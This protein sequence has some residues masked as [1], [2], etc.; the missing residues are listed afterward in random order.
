MNIGEIIQSS[1]CMER[2]VPFLYL[3]GTVQSI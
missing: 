3:S 1:S 2:A